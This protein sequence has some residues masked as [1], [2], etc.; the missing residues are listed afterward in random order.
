MLLK[1]LSGKY[2]W[3]PNTAGLICYCHLLSVESFRN[4]ALWKRTMVCSD[5]TFGGLNY[6]LLQ[7][8]SLTAFT[9]MIEDYIA[10]ILLLQLKIEGIMLQDR[11]VQC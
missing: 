11:A 7:Y 1:E 6:V 10:I 2:L 5:L 3:S 4:H 9:S 8:G